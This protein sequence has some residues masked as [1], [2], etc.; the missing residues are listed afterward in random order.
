MLLM[1]R[2]EAARQCAKQ[3]LIQ[4]PFILLQ[5][6]LTALSWCACSSWVLAGPYGHSQVLSCL[7]L[8]GRR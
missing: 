3:S 2:P 7:F 5:E 8:A 4:L 1:S 6:S